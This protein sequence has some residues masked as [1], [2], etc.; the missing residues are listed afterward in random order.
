VAD[1]RRLL[2]FVLAAVLCLGALAGYLVVEHGR[3]A[4][5]PGAAGGG[6][7]VAAVQAVPH[8]VVRDTRAGPTYGDIALIP[9]SDP[10]GPRADVPVKCERVAATRTRVICL[11]QVSAVG[12]VYRA[13]FLDGDFRQTG[14]Q[15]LAGTPSRAR[16][17]SGGSWTASTVFRSGDSYAD[18][19]FSVETVI[20]RTDGQ[21][22]LGDLETWT[23]TQNGVP[24]TSQDRNFWGVTFIGDGP[25]FYATMA[26]GGVRHLVKGDV[27]TRTMTVVADDGACP[28]VSADGSTVVMKE[29]DPV[30]KEDHLVSL[31][32]ASGH[33]TPLQEGRVVDDQVTWDGAGTVLYAVGKGIRTGV[34]FDVWSGPVDGSAPHLLVSD[35]SS[36][37]VVLPP[38]R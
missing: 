12:P 19:T 38:G 4:A 24:V 32:L 15:D 23:A 31:D 34:D 22:S 14:T 10:G 18:V 7:P 25:G 30:S 20:T 36:P 6:L 33:R 8:L 16:V 29:Q 11:Q 2:A 28:S 3:S 21:V 13:V 26:T 9:L 1:R 5:A 35:A 17:S 27:R 37:S